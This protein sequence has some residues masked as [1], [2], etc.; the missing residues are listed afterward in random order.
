M[1][2]AS[3]LLDDE[4]FF[5]SKPSGN[6]VK[7][8]G[9]PKAF[10]LNAMDDRNREQWAL[11]SSFLIVASFLVDAQSESVA[12]GTPFETPALVNQE[13]NELTEAILQVVGRDVG[14]PLSARAAVDS[15]TRLFSIDGTEKKEHRVSPEDQFVLD[16][17]D[18]PE[19]RS[20]ASEF[21]PARIADDVEVDSGALVEGPLR[22][23]IEAVSSGVGK[24]FSDVATVLQTIYGHLDFIL[25]TRQTPFEPILGPLIESP[26]GQTFMELLS[27]GR[28]FPGPKTPDFEIEGLARLDGATNSLYL[29]DENLYLQS[30]LN[31][32]ERNETTTADNSDSVSGLLEFGAMDSF[33]SINWQE[34][35]HLGNRSTDGSEQF[36]AKTGNIDQDN[37]VVLGQEITALEFLSLSGESV[38]PDELGST[39][40]DFLPYDIDLESAING[41]VDPLLLR[42]SDSTAAP[43]AEP[44]S[45]FAVQAAVPEPISTSAQSLSG[46]LPSTL[47]MSALLNA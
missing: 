36:I 45:D 41:S 4:P 11:Y 38:F 17:S 25:G 9:I 3:Q 22:T 29:G 19:L 12:M 32:S 20:Y 39:V 7:S 42:A 37:P 16:R 46:N 27:I 34:G 35:L 24:S 14:D 6:D 5:V 28:Q 10:S 40:S 13:S 31:R 33:G 43:Q 2:R 18:V 23:L 26:A 44:P 15:A 1:P 30:S 8:L 47:D 21:Q